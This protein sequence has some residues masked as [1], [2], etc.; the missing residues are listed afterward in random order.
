MV[1]GDPDKGIRFIDRVHFHLFD[2][3]FWDKGE[4]DQR[5]VN[6]GVVFVLFS[7]DRLEKG[8]KR[9]SFCLG[10]RF[11]LCRR[12]LFVKIEV[13]EPGIGEFLLP[14]LGKFLR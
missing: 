13:L 3:G 5:A 7:T 9:G 4:V 11:D 8:G 2:A 6:L 1:V 12:D 10:L 14:D